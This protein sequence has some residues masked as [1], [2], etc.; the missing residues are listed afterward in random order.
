MYSVG[1][2]L[3][4]DNLQRMNNRKDKGLPE[5]CKIVLQ[6][7][8]QRSELEDGARKEEYLFRLS[9]CIWMP[10][11]NCCWSHK[12]IALASGFCIASKACFCFCTSSW[13]LQRTL[14]RASLSA[15]TLPELFSA[16]RRCASLVSIE[17]ATGL[18]FQKAANW[19]LNQLELVV[20]LP[21]RSK[22]TARQSLVC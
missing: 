3:E 13:G 5:R 16:P 22:A 20:V 14:I 10:W 21:H 18:F 17:P 15:T 11:S 6:H 12:S 19:S 1:L 7:S 4:L 9:V 2:W 8:L